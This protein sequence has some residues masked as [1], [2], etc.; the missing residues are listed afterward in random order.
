MHSHHQIP[1]DLNI[2]IPHGIFPHH[3]NLPQQHIQQSVQPEDIYG[4]QKQLILL[5]Q[6]QQQLQQQNPN[7]A[8]HLMSAQYLHHQQQQ[9]Q[10]QQHQHQQHQQHQ[11]QHQ[12]PFNQ[13]MKE[14]NENPISVQQQI[15]QTS[16]S[17]SPQISMNFEIYAESNK[18]SNGN[19]NGRGGVGPVIPVKACNERPMLPP[20]PIPNNP[21][22]DLQQIQQ[23]MMRKKI[24]DMPS[25]NNLPKINEQINDVINGDLPPPPS[26][27][28]FIN[29]ASYS[30]QNFVSMNTTAN[31]MSKLNM[32]NAVN[33]DTT[34]NGFDIPLP[35]PPV[36]IQVEFNHH[37][38]H[39]HHHH[40][41]HHINRFN[42]LN[43]TQAASPLPSP[44][45][46]G[47]QM[48][49]SV[50]NT[51]PPPPPLPPLAESDSASTSSSVSITKPITP[52]INNNVNNNSDEPKTERSCFLEDINNRRYQLKST[53]KQLDNSNEKSKENFNSRDTI[54][55]LVNN[56]DVA[57]IIDFIRKF[58]PHVRDSSDDDEENSDWDE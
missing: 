45:S 5:K 3:L 58:R 57:A 2:N 18:F 34:D 52:A 49:Q 46:P 38:H 25:I 7:V 11:H 29:D 15:H 14:M 27:P 40:Q 39:N 28:T 31:L 1:L 22:N 30:K 21:V 55:P 54:Q 32:N 42:H 24:T 12:M 19:R 56:S 44:P 53:Q 47:K 8:S 9:Q 48:S 37:H 33:L 13:I 36:E 23:Q 20:P 41:Q 4:Q 43:H 17:Q 16:V 6:Q 10:H 35:P 50:I 51:L 26:P